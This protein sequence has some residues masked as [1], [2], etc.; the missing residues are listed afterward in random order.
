[1]PFQKSSQ[2]F[3]RDKQ[4]I[5]EY[6]ITIKFYIIAYRYGFMK[7]IIYKYKT[8]STRLLRLFENIYSWLPVASL[9]DDHIF[10]TH[11]GISDLT[12]LDKIKKIKRQK[13]FI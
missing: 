12:D 8:H 9:I 4:E 6:M 3:E 2:F 1:M 11:G 7:E 13:V 10:V 5:F